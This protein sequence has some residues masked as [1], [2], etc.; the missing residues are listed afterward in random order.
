MRKTIHNTLVK[1]YVTCEERCA[2]ERVIYELETHKGKTDDTSYYFPINGATLSKKD[3]VDLRALADFV[4]HEEHVPI[5]T[6]GFSVPD[7]VNVEYTG[8]V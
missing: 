4:C 8:G 3:I 1:T 7:D 5:V 2:L 6:F